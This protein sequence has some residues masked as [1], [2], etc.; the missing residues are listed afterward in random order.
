MRLLLSVPT[1]V[2][3]DRRVD[4]VVA[5]SPEGHFCLL[6][7]HVDVATVLVPGLLTYLDEDGVEAVVAVDHG[8][9]VKVGDEVRVACERAQVAPDAE[10]AARAVRERFVVQS[11]REKRAR[12]TLARLE[13]DM[14][15]RL[16]ALRGRHGA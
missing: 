3:L 13:V 7:R 10:A 16:G 5:E 6:P 2:L 8:V 12:A 15:R 1:D 11:E 4:K 14:V 9:L